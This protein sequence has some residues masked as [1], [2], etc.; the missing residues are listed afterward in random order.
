MIAAIRENRWL[1]HGIF[2]VL[3]LAA[4]VIAFELLI[5]PI[6]ALL[7]ERDAEIAR[8]RQLLARLSAMAAQA[9]TIEKL[10]EQGKSTKD[11]P[12]FLRGPNQSVI[13]ADL[14]S[15]LSAMIQ[16]AGGHVRSIRGLPPKTVDGLTLVGAQV[17]LS[18]PLRAVQQTV[19]AIEAS[20]PFLFIMGAAIKPSMQVGFQGNRA[21]TA[22][23]QTL[24][25][26][27]DV[28]GA[29]QPEE[30]D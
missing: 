1:R 26:R 13:T 15:R 19:Y 24:D 11:R 22:A 2:V 18:G 21:N 14:Q 8:Q 29:L 10:V 28:V 17:E 5:V 30:H 4:I 6:R 12:E 16:S 27:L 7:S 20:T 3:N 9:P 23:A 25:A